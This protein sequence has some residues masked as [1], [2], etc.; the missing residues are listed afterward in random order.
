[1]FSLTRV[2]TAVHKARLWIVPLTTRIST[3]SHLC[4]N[5]RFQQ[6]LRYA[7]G[8]L[9]QLVPVKYLTKMVG[10]LLMVSFLF[11]L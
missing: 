7:P 6:H 2:F 4:L 8:F 11:Q 5:D 3:H 1:M 9:D 10:E